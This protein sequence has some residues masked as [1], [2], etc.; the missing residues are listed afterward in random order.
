ME[1]SKWPVLALHVAPFTPSWES[2]SVGMRLQSHRFVQS[3]SWRGAADRNRARWPGSSGLSVK[4]LQS[5]LGMSAPFWS[6]APSYDD[7]LV[8]SQ[9]SFG[10]REDGGMFGR[11][12][13]GWF[14]ASD[15]PRRW[16]D[17][18]GRSFKPLPSSLG[19]HGVFAHFWRGRVPSHGLWLGL[20]QFLGSRPQSPQSVR[21]EWCGSPLLIGCSV[22]EPIHRHCSRKLCELLTGSWQKLKPFSLGTTSVAPRI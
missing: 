12:S 4:P 19:S 17:C 21:H 8:N 3:W 5:W 9:S 13:F 20:Q 16:H 10:Q 14:G 1:H 18:S 2:Q 11:S 15:L 22:S 6:S 7:G